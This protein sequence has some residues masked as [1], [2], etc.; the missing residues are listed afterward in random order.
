MSQP[1]R[2]P[3]LIAAQISVAVLALLGV[4]LI[5]IELIHGSSSAGLVFALICC[6]ALLAAAVIEALRLMRS[7]SNGGKR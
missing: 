7:R 1:D 4:V 5:G 3:L 6:I 2:S